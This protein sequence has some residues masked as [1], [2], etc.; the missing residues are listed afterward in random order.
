MEEYDQ[1]LF[2]NAET[3]DQLERFLKESELP[4]SEWIEYFCSFVH[5][6]GYNMYDTF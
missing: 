2:G 4:E 5:E 6:N 3:L 1:N